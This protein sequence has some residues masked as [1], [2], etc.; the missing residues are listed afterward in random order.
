VRRIRAGDN[1][2]ASIT[3][4]MTTADIENAHQF[5]D[6]NLEIILQNDM[7]RLPGRIPLAMQD[8]TK[9]ATDDWLPWKPVDSIVSTS[10]INELEQAI[11]L[12]YP[13]LYVEFLQYKHFCELWPVAEITFFRHEIDNWRQ[14]LLN[15]YHDAWLPEQLIDKGYIYF[16][17][18]SDWGIVCFDTNEQRS[19][20]YD[21]P[22]IMIDHELLFDKPVPK[23]TLYSSF[24]EMMKSLL[25]EQKNPTES[26]EE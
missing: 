8:D 6:A 23:K 14:T 10:A 22:I 12:R 21:C 20:D 4:S 7:M 18:Y 15:R 26:D 9:T 17:D 16:A 2:K 3:S 1:D 25:E 11:K 24:A 13:K 19:D 5:I